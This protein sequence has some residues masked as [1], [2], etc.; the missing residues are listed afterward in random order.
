MA[1]ILVL[2]PAPV[3]RAR[4]AGLLEAAGHSVVLAE[5]A[6]AAEDRLAR[7][8]AG[9][10]QLLVMELNLPDRSG[11]E[12]IRALKSAP[13]T[14]GVP[15]LVVTPQPPRELVIDLILAGAENVVSKPFA[16][17][18]LLRRVTEI[19]A[20]QRPLRQSRQGEISWSLP[21]YLEREMKRSL[22]SGLPLSVVVA[23]ARTPDGRPV[24][25]LLAL[26][27]QALRVRDT[28]LVFGLET[29]EVVFLLPDTDR[30]G[31][32]VVEERIARALAGGAAGAGSRGLRLF[33]GTAT[34]PADAATAGRL[35]DVALERARSRAG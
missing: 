35:L 34:A 19:L 7:E 17:E 27:V 1:R 8:P 14:A 25:D 12:L 16:S 32:Q 15:V 10:F 30:P 9:S 13:A 31:A 5:T 26:L 6:R 28:D 24:P 21:E 33:T 22:R 18:V 2:E 23:L 4:I 29:G 11:L 3:D 20:G